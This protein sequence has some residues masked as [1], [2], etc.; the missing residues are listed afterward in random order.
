VGLESALFI[1][2]KGFEVKGIDISLI[3]VDLAKE[4]AEQANSKIIFGV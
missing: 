1:W 2:Q 4:K 3:A